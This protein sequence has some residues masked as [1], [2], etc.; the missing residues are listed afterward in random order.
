[1]WPGGEDISRVYKHCLHKH[2]R[3]PCRENTTLICV[4]ERAVLQLWEVMTEGQIST[5]S[6]EKD[7]LTG[8]WLP[9]VTELWGD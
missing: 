5:Q 3:L 7:R 4:A 8:R 6:R 1:M 9:G 2:E